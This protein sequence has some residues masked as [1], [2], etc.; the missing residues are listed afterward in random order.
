CPA[1][2][3]THPLPACRRLGW[4]MN[5]VASKG[6][7]SWLLTIAPRVGRFAHNGLNRFLAI[8]IQYNLQF[9]GECM[10]ASSMGALLSIIYPLI[11]PIHNLICQLI[12]QGEA[13]SWLL[14]LHEALGIAG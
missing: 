9:A 14:R 11:A 12:W 1:D 10:E 13:P 7:V 4:A 3:V 5:R 6:L 8:Q 2:S